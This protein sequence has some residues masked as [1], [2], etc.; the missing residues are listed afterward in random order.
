MMI[1]G[2][3]MP[4]ETSGGGSTSFTA[5]IQALYGVAYTL[6]FELKKRGVAAAVGS[7]EALWSWGEVEGAQPL[8]Q[9][10]VTARWTALLP[11]PDE[12]TAEEIDAAIA[13]LRRKKDP[14]ALALLRIETLAEG[15]CAEVMHVGA[16]DAEQ[17][18]IERLHAAIADAG[19]RPRGRHHEIYLGDPRRTPPQRLRT[20][21]RQPID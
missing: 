11:V 6:H 21:I 15:D 7:L 16:Y 4:D 14:P 10:D 1:D 8:F 20:I 5:A 18:T 17:P 3:G 13:E 2:I 9:P 12:A 19:R